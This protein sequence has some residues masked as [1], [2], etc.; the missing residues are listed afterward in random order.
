[1]TAIVIIDYH[2]L[3]IHDPLQLIPTSL[4]LLL[5]LPLMMIDAMFLPL[6]EIGILEIETLLLLEITVIEIATIETV[7]DEV[8]LLLLLLLPE[9][10]TGLFFPPTTGRPGI[11]TGIIETRRGMSLPS[12]MPLPAGTGT[13]ITVVP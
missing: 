10:E 3:P 11:E 6:P 2:D 12:M 8:T 1:M 5:L 9:T 7:I 4:L 13:E